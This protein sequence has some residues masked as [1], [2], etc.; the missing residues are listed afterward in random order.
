MCP[1]YLAT[2]DEKDST[3]GRARVLQE[4]LDGDAGRRPGRP[5][6]GRGARPVPGLQGLRLGLPDRRRHGHLQGRGAAPALR[7]PGATERR[8]RSHYLLGRLPTLG[9]ARRAGGAAGQRDDAARPAGPRWPGPP[10]ASTSAARIPTFAPTHAAPRRP[11]D[12][13]RTVAE[14][15]RDVWVWADSF[16]DHFFPQSGHAAIAFLEAAGLRVRVI[17]ERRLL[18]ADLGHHRPARP[19]PRRSWGAPCATLAPYVA[20]GVPVLGLEPSCLAT[21]RSDAVELTDDPRAA[22]GRRRAC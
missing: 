19:G 15:R 17:A 16:T 2:R 7:R 18:R 21:L 20:S 22:R 3:R 12:R 4:A 13:R 1:S 14:R 8:P 6:R 10:P 11:R 9:R 5:G